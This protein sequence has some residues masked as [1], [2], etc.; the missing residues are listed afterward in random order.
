[1]DEIKGLFFCMGM[2]VIACVLV[3]LV[4]FWP[5]YLAGRHTCAAKAERL[6]LEYS[7]GV[8]QGCFV[9]DGDRWVDYENYRVI[10][11]K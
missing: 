1:M 7:F 5:A 11:G 9:K 2:G 8:F 3:G 10:L 4:I 6:G